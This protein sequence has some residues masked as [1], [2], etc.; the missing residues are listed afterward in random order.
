M[1]PRH[2]T[3]RSTPCSPGHV[4]TA[5]GLVL[6]VLCPPSQ[7]SGTALQFSDS[8]GLAGVFPLIVS[9]CLSCRF[10]HSASWVL[11]FVS[12]IHSPITQLRKHHCCFLGSTFLRVPWTA[13]RSNQSILKE[14]SPD[15]SLEG[16]MLKLK[17]QN[18][19]HLM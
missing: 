11:A 15:S 4:G 13:R 7:A 1:T 6:P 17:L 12:W 18:F 5:L 3:S 8:A 10:T 2:V 19:G 14:T 9:S 16:L